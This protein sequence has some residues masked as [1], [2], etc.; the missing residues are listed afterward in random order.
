[1]WEPRCKN[2]VL[3]GREQVLGILLALLEL[4]GKGKEPRSSVQ[5]WR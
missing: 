2:L 3:F 1:V 4:S 5:C